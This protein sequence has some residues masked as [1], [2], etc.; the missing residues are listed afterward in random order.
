MVTPRNGF[1]FPTLTLILFLAHQCF[2]LF[3]YLLFSNELPEVSEYARMQFHMMT[4][5]DVLG[6]IRF[7]MPG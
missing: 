7:S 2:Y 1:C 3:I 6:K 5:L 4:L